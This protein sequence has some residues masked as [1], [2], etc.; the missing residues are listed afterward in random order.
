LAREVAAQRWSWERWYRFAGLFLF[1]FVVV[2][3][4]VLAAQAVAEW[5]DDRRMAREAEAQFAEARLWA[6]EVARVQ[7][8][9]ATVGPC[10]I[11][12]ARAVAQAAARGDTMSASAIGRP[13]LPSSQMPS[14]SEDVRSAAIARIGKDRMDAIVESEANVQIM[15]ETSLRIRDRWSTFALLDPAN[16]PPS[17]VDRSNVRLA[18]IG[19]IDLIRVMIYNDPSAQMEALAVPRAEWKKFE[20][21][22]APIDRCGL[23]RDWK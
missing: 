1:E 19:V 10:L 23:I 7:T 14:W 13:A 2:L 21:P 9:W 4:G 5:A 16:G 8:Y 15:M 3:L 20:I 22:G 6:I 18:A 17:D 11:G 12:R